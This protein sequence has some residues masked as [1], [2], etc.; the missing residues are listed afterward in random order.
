[1]TNEEILDAFCKSRGLTR[2]KGATRAY[3]SAG[4]KKAAAATLFREE[5][6]IEL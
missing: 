6:L 4:R 5:E 3:K 1:M 2:T